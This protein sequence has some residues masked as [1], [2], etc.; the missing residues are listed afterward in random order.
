MQKESGLQGLSPSAGIAHCKIL[1]KLASGL[2]KP[3][4]QTL[5]TAAAVPE[6][7]ADLPIPKLRQLG[8]KFGD[9]VMRQ[10]N[11]QTV[12]KSPAGE[13]D[14]YAPTSETVQIGHALWTLIY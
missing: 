12:G 8:G 11:L 5:V 6:L 13:P 10:L 3:S 14:M 1:A 2:H 7:L 9:D 4:Q